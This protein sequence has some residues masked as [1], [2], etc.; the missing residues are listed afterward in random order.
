MTPDHEK[1]QGP[2]E[3]HVL[4]SLRSRINLS[5]EE[6]RNYE[7][8]RKGY[9]GEL[10]FYDF[11]Q[12]KI[13]ENNILL[14]SLRLESNNSEFQL[15][16]VLFHQNGLYLF[17]VKNFEGDF[18]IEN[19][20]WY[21]ASTGKEINNPLIQLK[22]SESLMRQLIQQ[23]GYNLTVES[24]IVFINPEFALFQASIRLPIILR[25]Q[26]NRFFD[27]TTANIFSPTTNHKRLRD[28]LI[29]K[30]IERSPSERLPEYKFSELKKG[31]R[32]KMC[33]G[34]LDYLHRTKLACKRCGHEELIDHAVLRSIREFDLL[35]PTEKIT[36]NVMFEWC[37]VVP[38][39]TIWRILSKHLIKKERARATHYLLTP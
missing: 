17:E 4:N 24:Y 25:A 18:Y 36:T 39:K 13:P 27:K 19:N 15:D 33:S 16:S 11:L 9:I 32:C 2:L 8:L 23:S 7:N 37:A 28:L 10:K 1:P 35:F 34:F 26:L 38:R 6:K 14:N 31:I 20:N 3:F 22:R 29:S 30:H 21:V 12:T 5:Q